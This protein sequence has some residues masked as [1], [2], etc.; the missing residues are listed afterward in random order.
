MTSPPAH[1]PRP[2]PVITI[3]PQSRSVERRSSVSFKAAVI[4]DRPAYFK[5]FLDNFYN[6]DVLRPA[7]ISDQAWQ[8]SFNVAAMYEKYGVSA[9]VAYNYRSSFLSS[10]LAGGFTPPG[11][12]T[13]SYVFPVYTKGYGWLEPEAAAGAQAV[14][15]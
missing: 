1:Q 15:A 6:V 5:D 11:G 14:K 12:S 4:A 8:N 9:R 2:A 10:I 3:A 7:R 13:V